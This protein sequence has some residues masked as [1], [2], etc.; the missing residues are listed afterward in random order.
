MFGRMLVGIDGS[1]L[2]G[3]VAALAADLAKSCGAAL[4]IFCAIDPAY[5]IEE[6]DGERPSRADEIDYP[7]AALES[8][9]ADDLV[10][11]QVAELRSVGI[12]AD[13][14]VAEGMPVAAILHATATHGCDA[15]IIGHR[16]LSWLG[17]IT[18][19]SICH[20]LLEQAAV[21]VVVVPANR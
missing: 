5:F 19:R 17:K 16:H 10:R 2:T 4:H 18:E 14:S 13:G 9:S 12:D 8:E 21:P 15:I 7:A 20:M 11:R 3:N 6:P 1:V